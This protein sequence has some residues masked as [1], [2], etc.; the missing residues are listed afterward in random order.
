MQ[1]QENQIVVE[2]K[3]GQFAWFLLAFVLG[4][5]LRLWRLGEMSFT[6]AEAQLAESTWQMALGQFVRLPGNMSYTGLSAVLF[7]LFEPS[8]FF[9]RLIPAIAGSSLILLP[10]FWRDTIREKTALV[11]AFGLAFDPI[12]LSFSRLIVTPI[13]AV[14]GAAWA[15]TAA[16]NRRPVLAGSL[17]AVGWLGGY[18][19]WVIAICCAALLAWRKRQN[20]EPSNCDF[21]AKAFW[22]PFVTSFIISLALIST[23]FLLYTPGL[24]GVGAGFVEFIQLFGS[25][26][27]LPIYQPIITAVA[28]SI[29]PLTFM[30]WGIIEDLV[31]KRAP[32]NLPAFVGWGLSVILCVLLGR[33]D[34]GL[35]VM[36]AFCAWLGAADQ[37][38]TILVPPM[39]EKEVRV[40]ASLFQ[41]VILGYLLMISR[42]LV[43]VSVNPQDFRFTLFALAAGALLLVISTILIN[44]GWSGKIGSESLKR[45]LLII[46]IIA[47]FGIS[48]RSIEAFKERNSLSLLAG[49]ILMPNH[50]TA[51]ALEE[52]DRDGFVDKTEA[53]VELGNLQE[54]FAWFFRNQNAPA[55]RANL[56]QPDLILSENEKAVSTAD[57]YRG[58][59]VVLYR[60]INPQAVKPS[61]FLF[62]LF[63]KPLPVADQSGVLWVRLNL[64][65][66]AN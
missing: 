9:T 23:A 22:L 41:I 54:Q 38:A 34:L 32:K 1:D 15:V 14:A 11:L 17:L 53:T 39:E 2:K 35:L 52:L 49:P 16:K 43:G 57:E 63:G 20:A 29:L 18:S 13:L 51:S 8:F 5:G 30:I 19:F 47:A 4:L 46:L 26:Y 36:A 37:I 27:Q 59:N 21:R 24:G 6:L 55:E 12:L 62:V 3:G 48:L 7:H 40:G 10:W 56:S 28:Y 60:W 61:D 25:S 31:Q 45:S 50:D 33:Q 65:T 66:G 58:K 42:R 44:F 64:F